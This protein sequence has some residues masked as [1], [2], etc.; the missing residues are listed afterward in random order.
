MTRERVARVLE[1]K[2]FAKEMLEMEL[3]RGIKELNEEKEKL[4]VLEDVL[5][6]ATEEFQQRCSEGRT[7]ILTLDLFH[8]YLMQMT[9]QIHVQRK[10]V[11]CKD[12]AVQ[13][14]RGTFSEAYKE[15]RLI[16]ILHEKLSQREL[17][18]H[19]RQEQKE[20]DLNYSTKRS[21]R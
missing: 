15:E 4:A 5:A 9:G 6:K 8:G 14:I 18:E 12:A 1:L 10:A 17:K 21:R 2:T 16:E 7:D 20:I 3:A 11:V 19:M 13:E